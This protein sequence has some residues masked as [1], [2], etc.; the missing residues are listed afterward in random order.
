MGVKMKVKEMIKELKKM[1][2]NLDF[3]VSVNGYKNMMVCYSEHE[4]F[5]PQQN[6]KT[7]EILVVDDRSKFYKE[8][9]R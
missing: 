1:N 3:V 7:V 4:V 8:L 9:T 6:G 2:Q 5:G